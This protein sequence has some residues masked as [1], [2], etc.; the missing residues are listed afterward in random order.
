MRLST[1]E[2]IS[3][4]RYLRHVLRGVTER[5][6]GEEGLR[7]DLHAHP[8]VKDAAGARHL[9]QV[10]QGNRVALMAYTAHGEGGARELDYEAWKGLMKRRLPSHVVKD[11]G[12]VVRVK[13]S[14]RE[15]LIVSGYEE[16][17]E[18][19][20]VQGRLCLVL[21]ACDADV[22]KHFS[23][24]RPFREWLSLAR[25]HGGL[26]IASH[27][28][29]LWA[30]WGPRGMIPFRLATARERAILRREVFPRVDGVD[31][32]ATNVA[33]MIRSNDLL[34]RDYPGRPLC[35][36]DTHGLTPALRR[37]IGTS[38]CLFP[39]CNRIES[40]SAFRETLRDRLRKGDFGTYLRYLG[41]L[42]FARSIAL[43]SPSQRHP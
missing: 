31:L 42:A 15:H 27:P 5:Q 20:G 33:W 17:C 36:S 24:T 34:E 19:P 7:A 1:V 37:A 26:V 32:V 14:H 35:T 3:S 22:K 28:Y 41:P 2:G 13:S 10:L 8:F 18:V 23:G 4:L 43:G 38:G 29:T 40:A 16:Y 30:P 25:D 6:G 11:M 39:S 12:P 21:L 9:L